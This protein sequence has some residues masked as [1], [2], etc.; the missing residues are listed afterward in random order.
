[1]QAE[2]STVA[3]EA[4]GDRLRAG[5]PVVLDGALGTELERRGA[6][7][8]LPLWS[9]HALLLR[10]ELVRAIHG[11]YVA[12]GAEVL[13]AN[14]F[15][16]QRR[17]LAR[18]G[19][20]ERAAALTAE[21]VALARAA[22]AGAGAGRRVLVAGSIAPLEDCYHPERVP[23]DAA[24]ARE[25]AEHAQNLAAAGADLLLVETMNTTREAVAAARA[26]RAT[27]LPTWVSFV[28]G[29]DARLLSGEPL[30]LALAAVAALHPEAV[31]VNCLPP[32]DVPPCL[33]VLAGAGTPF[34]VYANLGAPDADGGFLR[35]DDCS[36]AAFGAYA[37]GWARAGARILGGCCGTSPAHVRAVAE[38]VGR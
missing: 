12:A 25:H 33:D 36:P 13:T 18:A 23:D 29:G 7:S 6:P 5:R 3:A 1:V 31:L 19:L 15:R 16:T 11:D 17:T 27:G 30:A 38:A 20:G 4:L 35:S 37:A 2:R 24:L 32:R 28:C 21:A 26:A 22:A 8:A 34:G 14:T 10:P 9:A